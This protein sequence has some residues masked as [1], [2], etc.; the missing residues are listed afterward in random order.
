MTD[1]PAG[2]T[3]RDLIR[4]TDAYHK[5]NCIPEI[6]RMRL[7]IT[8]A[9]A[10]RVVVPAVP[11]RDMMNAGFEVAGEDLKSIHNTYRAMIAA[12]GDGEA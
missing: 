2:V 1:L 9:L 11:T 6:Y 3:E 8:A 7:A 5:V 4:A 10:G 12:A